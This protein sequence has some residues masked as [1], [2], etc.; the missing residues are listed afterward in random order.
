MSEKEKVIITGLEL[1]TIVEALRKLME[2]PDLKFDLSWDIAKLAEVVDKEHKIY[3]ELRRK[4]FEKHGEK[5]KNEKTGE[6]QLLIKK[7][8][9]DLAQ[10]DFDDLNNKEIVLEVVKLRR[11]NFEGIKIEPKTILSLMKFFKH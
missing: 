8:K 4:V 6:E 5:I 1:A 10:K 2:A 11:E 9:F 7:E 3:E